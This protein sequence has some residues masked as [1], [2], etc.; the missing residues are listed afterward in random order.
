MLKAK[1]LFHDRELQQAKQFCNKALKQNLSNLQA[2]ILKGKIA[3]ATGKVKKARKTFSHICS[4]APQSPDGHLLLGQLAH[5]EKKSEKALTQYKTALKKNP[6]SL[7]AISMIVHIHM[8][9]K[10]LKKALNF[11]TNRINNHLTSSK[12]KAFILTQKG[13]VLKKSR[14]PQKAE[15][16]CKRA[17][18]EHPDWTHPYIIIANIHKQ[19]ENLNK[20]IAD[21]QNKQT[22]H[23]GNLQTNMKLGML[24]EEQGKICKAK[25]LY[26]KCLQIDN[27]FSPAAN[28]LSSILLPEK[29]KKASS[30]IQR[31]KYVNPIDPWISVTLGKYYAHESAYYNAISQYKSALEKLPGNPKIRYNL[32]LLHRRHDNNKIAL[33]QL[34]R[35]VNSGQSFSKLSNAKRLIADLEKSL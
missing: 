11:C 10:N 29:P 14:K 18:K 33:E 31:A 30:L 19:N 7:Q 25:N 9:N 2:H 26:R 23:S 27:K 22:S 32:A 21:L 16:A 12:L 8:Q 3:L 17:I 6:K 35:A 20:A 15:K 4:L 1:L 28:R 24:Y 5:R 34:K 13:L